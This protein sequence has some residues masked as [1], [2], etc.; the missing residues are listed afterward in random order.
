MFSNMDSW[1]GIGEYFSTERSLFTSRGKVA[2]YLKSVQNLRMIL[3]R[4]SGHMVPLSQPEFAQDMFQ[5]FISGQ[6]W[7]FKNVLM[8]VVC[9][10]H[11][12]KSSFYW[13]QKLCKYFTRGAAKPFVRLFF[14]IS[15]HCTVLEDPLCKWCRFQRQKLV[16]VVGNLGCWIRIWHRFWR[17][18]FRR[19]R[20]T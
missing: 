14:L 1:S 19:Y 8:T 17:G 3:M 6:L 18:R 4:N 2:G 9:T 7:F 16:P 10:Q 13:I 15:C 20:K 5:R 12:I 11:T